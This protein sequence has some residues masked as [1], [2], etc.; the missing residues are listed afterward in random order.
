MTPDL[1]LR[2]GLLSYRSHPHCGGQG[3]Y[4]SNLSRALNDLGHHVQV[5]S[6]PP[7]PEL[8]SNIPLAR[9]P[10]LDLYNPENLFRTPSFQELKDAINLVEWLGV[11]TM[12]FPE[13]LTFGMRVRK[14]LSNHS[15][16][17]DILHD[18]QCLAYG[19]RTLKQHVPVVA[20]IHHPITK[21]RTIAIRHARNFY[22]KLQQMRWYSF[23]HMQKKVAQSLP[24]LITVSQH[25]CRD[26]SRAFRVEPAR[27]KVIPNG[28]RTDLFYPIPEIQKNSNHIIVTSSADTPLKGLHYLLHAVAIVSQKR[29]VKVTVVGPCPSQNG[30]PHLIRTLDL[31]QCVSFLDRINHADFVKLYAQAGIAVVPSLYEGFGLPAGEAMACGVPVISTTAGGLPEVVGDAGILVPP[32]ETQP[33]VQA[34]LQLLENPSMAQ[35]LGLAG[36]KRVKERFTWR[37]AAQLTVKVYRKMLR[38]NHR[39]QKN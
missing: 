39:L 34:L 16:C 37:K 32:A 14:Y 4:I 25:A 26:I 9:L 31:G 5:V 8:D 12:G 38:D 19:I 33:L 20:T 29:T 18:N 3:V 24:A 1:P 36:Q 35:K 17:F 22:R 21:D 27:L 15:Q 23:I 10:S 2:I 7:Y 6:G 13:P 28:I 30:I 11:S